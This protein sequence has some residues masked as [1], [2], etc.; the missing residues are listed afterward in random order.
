M[1]KIIDWLK[2]YFAARCSLP[3]KVETINFF[4]AGMID[5]FGVIELIEV[6]EKEFGIQLTETQFQDRRFPTIAG[7]A[8]IVSEMQRVHL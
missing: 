3:E 1:Q 5:S 7:L 6:L 4:E 8:E 2:D